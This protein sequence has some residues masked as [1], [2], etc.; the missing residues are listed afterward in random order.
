MEVNYRLAKLKVVETENQLL[1]VQ[2][3]SIEPPFIPTTANPDFEIS[4]IPSREGVKFAGVVVALGRIHVPIEFG[5]E[6]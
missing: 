2:D 5:I 3:Q 4:T 1:E 6:I